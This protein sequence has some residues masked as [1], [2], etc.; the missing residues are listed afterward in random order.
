MVLKIEIIS[1]SSFVN[2][3]KS[4]ITLVDKKKKKVT[5]KNINFIY[6]TF[7]IQSIDRIELYSN[8]LFTK[9]TIFFPL[10]SSL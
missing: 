7:N 9:Q 10:I 8:K 1:S 4:P 2:K 6:H 3:T 5:I